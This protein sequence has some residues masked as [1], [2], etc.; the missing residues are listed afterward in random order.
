MAPNVVSFEKMALEVIPEKVFM[1]CV[2]ENIRTKCFPKTLRRFSVTKMCYG[3]SN[4]ITAIKP[5][6][7][8]TMCHIAVHC[9]AS[10]PTL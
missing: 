3:Y 1:I 2:G 9:E 4:L 10:E 8:F 7:Q 6:Y 5:H